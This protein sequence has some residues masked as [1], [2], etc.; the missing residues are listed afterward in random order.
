[1]TRALRHEA[2][3]RKELSQCAHETRARRRPSFAIPRVGTNMVS[4]LQGGLTGSA[5]TLMMQCLLIG[6]TLG[7]LNSLMV[8][9]ALVEVT[10]SPFFAVAF[11]LL[12]VSSATIV[13]IQIADASRHVRNI[14]LLTSF[15][16][17]NGVSGILCFL[18][19]RDWSHGITARSKV[20]LYALLGMCLA[21]SVS[22]SCLD[23]LARCES[24]FAGA[25]LVR[26]EW[27]IRV[28]A[29]TSMMTGA[30]FGLTFGLLDVEDEMMKSPRA[31][32]TALNR[33]AR[34]CYPLGSAS[35][36][37]SAVVA[38]FLEQKAEHDDPDLA[39]SRGRRSHLQDL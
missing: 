29:C 24:S 39:Y 30:L 11:G 34:V 8:N 12:F 22:F 5:A 6:G 1:M 2:R 14:C 38:R 36:A 15:A 20:P 32:R 25:L 37:L 10:C 26:T 9:S 13:A 17:L 31:F 23:L 28:I 19:E 16:L 27:Q 21:F 18:L 7:L 3:V 35:G 33:E 4:L